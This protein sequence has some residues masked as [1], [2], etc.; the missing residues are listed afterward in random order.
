DDDTFEANLVFL[1]GGTQ[2]NFGT[3][4][5]DRLRIWNS[6][7]GEVF[8]VLPDGNV[9][10]GTTTPAEA[11]H[12]SGGNILADRGS[13]TNAL[14]RSL[15]LGGARKFDGNPYAHIQFQNFDEDSGASDYI[16]AEILSTN[17]GGVD[18]GNLR[19]FVNDGS[20]PSEGMRIDREGNLQFGPT[21]QF[22]VPADTDRTVIVRGQITG[23][24]GN[25]VASQSTTGVSSSRASGDAHYLVSF[26]AGAFSGVPIVTVTAFDPT[27]GRL[28]VAILESVST[29]DFSV[30]IRDQQGLRFP[31]R[32]NFIAIGE[33]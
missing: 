11:L 20:G 24:D 9:G 31:A 26:P 17:D 28:R 5:D 21:L 27:N 29:D 10:I 4:N 13:A 12:V 8:T 15:V 32:F 6:A 23:S 33:R 25:I 7:S 30:F 3:P 2:Y 1:G 18:G 16:G 14:S 19:F 22:H